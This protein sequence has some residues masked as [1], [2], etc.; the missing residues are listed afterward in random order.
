YTLTF[1]DS[2]W[3]PRV[4]V[5]DNTT[6]DIVIDVLLNEGEETALPAGFYYED[7]VTIIEN[8]D[9]V[10]LTITDEEFDAAQRAR[11]GG[12]EYDEQYEPPT[13]TMY[14][15]TD[16]D[17][18]FEVSLEGVVDGY[19]N[20]AAI[21]SNAVVL[22]TEVFAEYEILEEYA[23]GASPTVAPDGFGSQNSELV[24]YVGRPQ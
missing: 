21:G 6:G 24:I 23:L 19:I 18:W 12:Y 20:T 8:N 9:I 16:L 7:G 2:D 14:F 5:I 10:L 13:P 15:S 1:D 3:P 17:E 22:T 11:W 4:T